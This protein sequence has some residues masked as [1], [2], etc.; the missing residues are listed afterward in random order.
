[1]NTGTTPPLSIFRLFFFF[2]FFY[3]SDDRTVRIVRQTHK[4]TQGG[5]GAQQGD[6][7]AP[8][9]EN[10]KKNRTNRPSG[11]RRILIDRISSSKTRHEWKAAGQ[12]YLTMYARSCR[13]I[14]ASRAVTVFN[15][16]HGARPR[17]SQ[18][19][20]VP[21]RILPAPVPDSIGPLTYLAQT[22]RGTITILSRLTAR[23]SFSSVQHSDAR[24]FLHSLSANQRTDRAGSFR[25]LFNHLIL[26]RATAI[27]F[28]KQIRET[29]L[30]FLL[31]M[32]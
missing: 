23:W 31:N 3:F 18:I 2:F 9:G 21:P 22:R 17:G 6:H 1:M 4:P 13:L 25:F 16:Q 5:E 10:R 7:S 11:H 32:S 20:A 26:C 8:M 15:L 29:D 24:R 30:R 28:T 19:K 12:M 27:R 14:C